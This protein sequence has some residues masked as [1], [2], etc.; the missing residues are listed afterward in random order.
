MSQDPL[1]QQLTKASGDV[2]KLCEFLSARK[3]WELATDA[4]QSAQD[5]GAAAIKLDDHLQTMIRASGADTAATAQPKS[6]AVDGGTLD[7]GRLVRFASFVRDLD[8]WLVA[9]PESTKNPEAIATLVELESYLSCIAD[10]AAALVATP[11]QA[12]EPEPAVETGEDTAQDDEPS[13]ESAAVDADVAVDAA[14][15]PLQLVLDDT[16]EKPLVQEFQGR[17]ELTS[18]CKVLVDGFLAAWGLE[19]SY[20]NRKKL[21]ESLLRWISSAPEGQVLILKMKTAEVPYKPYPNY[22][23]RDVLAGIEPEKDPLS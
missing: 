8:S 14:G 23:S 3:G 5:L 10:M 6:K 1:T 9:Q 13:V 16:D 22:V 21:L 20:Y 4:E 17:D 18:D 15:R 7:G 2:K 19:Y 11:V 12:D